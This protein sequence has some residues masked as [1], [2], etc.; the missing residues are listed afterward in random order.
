MTQ[1]PRDVLITGL[2]LVSSLGEGVDAHLARLTGAGSQPTIEAERFAPHFVHPL[3]AIDWSRQIPK[4]GDQR[5]MET[6]QKLGVYAA[7][8][9]LEDAEI[10]PDEATRSQI[11]MIVS[12]G[13]GERDPDVDALVMARARGADDPQPLM[14]EL[15]SSELRPTLFLA[16]LSNLMA[17][18]ISIVHKVTGS[19]RTFMGEE[20]AGMSAVQIAS[21]RIRSGQSRICLVGGAFSSERKD[22]LLNYELGGFL[23]RD[24]WRPVSARTDERAGLVPGSIGAFLVL[25]DAEHASERGATGY[26]RLRFVAGD[27]GSR[28]PERFAGRLDRLLGES[29]A[30]DDDLLVLSGATGLGAETAVERETVLRR[31][32]R[33]AQRAYGTMTGHG[34]EAQFPAGVALGAALLSASAIPAPAAGGEERAA[35]FA[36]KQVLVTGVGHVRGEGVCLLEPVGAS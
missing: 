34:F 18:N 9:A 17:G 16:Q 14:N 35:G 3:P 15:L 27:R 26:A 8:L 13:G 7:G 31:F 5:Q 4:K 1:A 28:E 24:E 20:S 33:A 12:A 36:P 11:D 30:A 10:A 6:W 23:L 19:S 22:L 25:E 21:A 32:P 2:G 29:G